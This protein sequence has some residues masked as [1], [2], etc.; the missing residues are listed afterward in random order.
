[1]LISIFVATSNYMYTKQT[2]IWLDCHGDDIY[3]V[4]QSIV[5]VSCAVVGG[6]KPC[7]LSPHCLYTMCHYIC[8]QR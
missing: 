5:G 2:H 8:V 1:M 4:E 7:L 3:A 6:A